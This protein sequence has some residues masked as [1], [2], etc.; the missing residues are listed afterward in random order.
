MM[1]WVGVVLII[2]AGSFI[3][4]ATIHILPEV[5]FGMNTHGDHHD[6]HSHDHGNHHHND[7]KHS[8]HNHGGSHNKM[9]DLM[10]IISGLMTPM[11]LTYMHDE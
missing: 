10:V 9:L 1:F 4:V 8:H 7:N 2:S 6:H 3:Y 11:L 5:L